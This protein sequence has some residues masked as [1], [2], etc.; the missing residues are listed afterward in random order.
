VAAVVKENLELDA[1]I[2]DVWQTAGAPSQWLTS[3]EARDAKRQ[4]RMEQ[5]GMQ[6]QLA[7]IEQAAS[8]AG[9]GAPLLKAVQDGAQQMMPQEAAA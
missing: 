7:M 1:M 2:R 5:E 3:T 4:Q 9:K 8:A 6:R